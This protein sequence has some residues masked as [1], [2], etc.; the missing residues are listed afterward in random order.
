MYATADMLLT[1]P[2]QAAEQSQEPAIEVVLV[3]RTDLPSEG[4]GETPIVG[5]APAVG[6]AIFN[7]TGLRLKS[8]PLAPKGIAAP[9]L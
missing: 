7:A 2:A 6:N 8:L 4:A 3:D 1:S 9:R 5:L